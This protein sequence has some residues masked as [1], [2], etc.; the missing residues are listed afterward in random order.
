MDASQL[1]G[2]N[3]DLPVVV[4]DLLGVAM[5]VYVAD[6]LVKR[7][8]KDGHRQPRQLS[9]CVPVA[10]PQMW[11]RLAPGL[12]ALLRWLT[13]DWWE[14]AFTE[15]TVLQRSRPTGLLYPPKL[16]RP[17]V[18]LY[19]GGLDSLAGAVNQALNP[20]YASGVLVGAQSGG[21]LRSL[22]NEQLSA[23][24]A[25][26]PEVRWEAVH[27]YRHP[28][29]QEQLRDW[30]IREQQQEKSQR[31]RAFLFLTFGAV[32][33][34]AYGVD[35]LHVYE[36]GVGAINL[37]YSAA[38]GGAD[39]TRAMHP[40]TLQMAGELFTA[41]FEHPLRVVNASRWRT[42]GEM[43]TELAQN[44]LSDLVNLT[45]SCDSYPLREARKQCGVC[46][47]CLLR[48][49]SLHAAG[50]RH[51]D[52]AAGLYRDDIYAMSCYS[53]TASH[54]PYQFMRQQAKAF[55]NLTSSENLMDFRLEFPVLDETRSALQ[56]TE[57]LSLPEIDTRLADLYRRY[58]LEFESFSQAVSG[59]CPGSA[60]K[61][62]GGDER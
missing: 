12:V 59:T 60:V 45:A 39:Q 26:L 29:G 5:A 8:R 62:Q 55:G 22:Q 18:G 52:H 23:L 21:R 14:L 51:L 9:L 7:A 28:F 57:G 33:A 6:R 16:D 48:R 61:P 3:S 11:E 25:R 38:F 20:A 30:S 58:A 13:T 32:T 40:R 34:Y 41:L 10:E 37:P 4:T 46:T 42:K 24:R 54:R 56:K 31:S 17:F 44:G 53:Q 1:W 19:S 47:S 49:L 15:D 2:L 50:L 36:N 27:G 35:T 43:C